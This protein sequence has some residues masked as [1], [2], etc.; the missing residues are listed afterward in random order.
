M[1][2]ARLEFFRSLSNFELAEL[3][4]DYNTALLEQ[5]AVFVSALFAYIIAAYFVG[6]SL[7]KFQCVSVSIVYCLFLTANLFGSFAM[8][9]SLIH[10]SYVYRG[11]DVTLAAY[12]AIFAQLI[13][14]AL[15]ILFMIK[16]QRKI[17][18]LGQ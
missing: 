13:A 15:S 2:E 18:L 16:E 3:A 9:S 5:Q 12:G 4:L 6:K 8:A 7:D 14:W 1:D 17:L 10:V 11:I